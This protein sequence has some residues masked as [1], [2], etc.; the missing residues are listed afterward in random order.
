MLQNGNKA[1]L[2]KWKLVFPRGRFCCRRYCKDN[3]IVFFFFSVVDTND[4]EQNVDL[5]I[6]LGDNG[7]VKANRN[8]ASQLFPWKC[9]ADKIA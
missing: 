2:L 9:V 5:F 8:G 6:H 7:D 1:A 3:N 4:T